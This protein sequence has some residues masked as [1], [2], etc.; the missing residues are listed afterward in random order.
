MCKPEQMRRQLY[1]SEITPLVEP[2]ARAKLEKLQ[3]AIIDGDLK[4]FGD[5]VQNF[6]DDPSKLEKFIG[7][8]QKNLDTV[9]SGIHVSAKDGVVTIYRDRAT[10]AI[11]VNSSDGKSTLR[12]ITT[13][14]DGLVV[15]GDGEVLNRDAASE[16]RNISNVATNSIDGPCYGFDRPIPVR[17]SEPVG[18]L[19]KPSV[20]S[21]LERPVLP[22]GMRNPTDTPPPEYAPAVQKP[23]LDQVFPQERSGR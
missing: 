5:A 3:N 18:P 21:I 1:S 17:P 6:K 23:S 15:K 14:P 20:P 7:E 8:L 12:P 9:N 19:L 10:C 22:P 11:D 16:M 2:E 13:T 4:G